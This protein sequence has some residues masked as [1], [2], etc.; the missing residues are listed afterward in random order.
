MKK[1]YPTNMYTRCLAVLETPLWS[2]RGRIVHRRRLLIT[3]FRGG[4]SRWSYVRN[5]ESSL[6]LN[7]FLQFVHGVRRIMRVYRYS[8][9]GFCYNKTSI[10]PDCFLVKVLLDLAQP[11]FPRFF[12]KKNK[13]F[14]FNSDNSVLF[15]LLFFGFCI[16]G[17]VWNNCDTYYWT[18]RMRQAKQN[19]RTTYERVI[20]S[21]MDSHT[22]IQKYSR[23]RD[24][25]LTLTDKR[26]E[27][28]TSVSCNP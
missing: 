26:T 7:C 23:Q 16:V 17:I 10:E 20:F 14:N 24:S 5:G 2:S 13:N 6:L 12:C 25:E 3:M 18:L 9:T 15:I 22:S 8:C 21:L 27:S 11:Q 28:D 1:G 19:F 4:G